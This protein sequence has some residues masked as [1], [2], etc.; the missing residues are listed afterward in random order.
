MNNFP[1]RRGKFKKIDKIKLLVQFYVANR[2]NLQG[3]I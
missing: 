1:K 3:K 2:S